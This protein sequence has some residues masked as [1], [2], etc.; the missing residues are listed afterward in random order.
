MKKQAVT[1]IKVN[2]NCS[3]E[4]TI[5][6]I[7]RQTSG[8]S[9]VAQWLRIHLPMQGTRI[10]SLV[11]EDPT[12]RR[13][14]KPMC[15]N[16]WACALEPASRKHWAHVLQLLKPVCLEPVLCNKRSKAT[17]MRSPHTTTKS[18][19]HS[20][21]LEKPHAQQRGPNVAKKKRKRKRQT[22]NWAKIFLRHTTDKWF[23]SKIYKELLQVSRKMNINTQTGISQMNKYWKQV[24]QKHIKRC[25]TSL[26][27][28]KM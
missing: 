12:C 27:F 26:V 18:N 3:S 8:T 11:W 1:C 28:N 25:S 22:S 16:Y 21:Q 7:E 20:P 2:D 9:L 17:T 19:P 5:N 23:L 6:V 4:G 10:R 15:H 24:A 14:T 13:A